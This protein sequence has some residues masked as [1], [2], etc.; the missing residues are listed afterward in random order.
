MSDK[1]LKALNGKKFEGALAEPIDTGLFMPLLVD[2]PGWPEY[3]TEKDKILRARRLAK[4]PEL[5]RHLGINLEPFNLSD[6]ANG[7]GLMMLYAVVAEKLA[8]LVVPGF[9]EKSRGKNAREVVRFTRM[10]IDAA[11]ALGKTPSDLDACRDILKLETPSLARAGNKSALEKKAKS[12]RN[13]VAKD[14]AG[15]ARRS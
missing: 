3:F 15:A 12:L 1:P 9:R 4:M 13:L 10:A 6:P 2:A 11:K 14:R 8:A 5:A 7:F